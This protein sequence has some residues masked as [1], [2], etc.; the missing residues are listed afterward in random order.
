MKVQAKSPLPPITT[1]AIS[2]TFT[3]TD[4]SVLTFKGIILQKGAL[5]G[6]IGFFQTRQ[7]VPI[8]YTGETGMVNLQGLP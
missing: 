8:D 1:G 3:H 6:G 7:P 5:A 4:D 2:G